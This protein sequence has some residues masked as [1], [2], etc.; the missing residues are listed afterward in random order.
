MVKFQQRNSLKENLISQ[1]MV[2]MDYNEFYL[3]LGFNLDHVFICIAPPP[4]FFSLYEILQLV[5]PGSFFEEYCHHAAWCVKTAH[6]L[7]PS[8]EGALLLEAGSVDVFQKMNSNT[9]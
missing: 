7:I 9:F 2:Y 8:R 6:I 3:H 5:L 4:T 1:D